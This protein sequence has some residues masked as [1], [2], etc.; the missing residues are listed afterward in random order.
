[1]AKIQERTQGRFVVSGV[2]QKGHVLV[3]SRARESIQ[4]S[5]HG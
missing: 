3:R 4:E 5:H 1:M 2:L